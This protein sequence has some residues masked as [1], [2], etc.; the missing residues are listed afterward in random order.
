[1]ISHAIQQAIKGVRHFAAYDPKIK[2]FIVL[3]N[4]T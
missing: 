2:L 4:L 1:M 3:L